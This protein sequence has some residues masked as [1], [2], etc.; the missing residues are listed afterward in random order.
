[1]PNNDFKRFI[2]FIANLDKEI[3]SRKSKVG[4]SFPVGLGCFLFQVKDTKAWKPY[5]M[6]QG[7]F[8]VTRGQSFYRQLQDL[9][10]TVKE[11]A[12]LINKNHEVNL[13]NWDQQDT[14]AVIYCSTTKMKSLVAKN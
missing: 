6:L 13:C 2:V 7:S 14:N 3:K 4:G 10:V 12:Q 9:S 1:M 5:E 8:D 11:G